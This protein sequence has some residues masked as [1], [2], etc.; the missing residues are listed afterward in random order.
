MKRLA[1]M[2]FVLALLLALSGSAFAQESSSGQ[3]AYLDEA[4]NVW[5][6]DSLL[7]SHT[8]LTGDSSDTRRYLWPTWAT[9][10]R[11]A[12]FSH[13]LE[14]GELTTGAWIQSGPGAAV[15]P[16][17][18]GTEAF[19]Y[20]YWSPGSCAA[21]PSCRQL[22]ILLS[23]QAQGMF[24]ELVTDGAAT[25]QQNVT[26]RGGPPFY[27]SW[28]FDGGRMLWQR[29]SRR[30]DIYDANED[31]L[32]ATLDQTPGLIQAPHW[33]PTDDRLLLGVREPDG[34]T[35]LLLVEGGSSLE[36]ASGL[37]GAVAFNWSPDGSHVGWREQTNSG[38]GPLHIAD[39]STGELMLSSPG[40]GVLAFV[41]APDGQR[42]AWLEFI[43]A[44][45]NVSAAA[46]NHLLAQTQAALPGLRW[47]VM[48]L[49]D[50]TTQDGTIFFPTPELLYYMTYF[51]QF[52]QSHRLW[53]PDSRF[54]VYGEIRDSGPLVKV[55]DVDRM[56]EVPRTLASGWMGVWD[57][58]TP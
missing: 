1:G 11:L 49:A 35:A 18:S 37:A 9:D 28:S 39:A 4:Y 50:G 13:T 38:F 32:L 43:P 33:S 41:W 3:I 27:F 20:A 53:S 46:G 45:G 12:W 31:R 36:L 6:Y 47:T 44:A 24:V 40:A 21:G 55:L 48:E 7:D 17:F 26:L 29:N 16:G 56:S 14:Q 54:L 8:R 57:F 42:I 15:V 34:R 52:A 22:A 2:S 51:D 25:A 19:N 23:S 58:G 30:F 5:R 10:G